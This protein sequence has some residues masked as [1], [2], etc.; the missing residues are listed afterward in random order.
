MMEAYWHWHWGPGPAA[1][2]SLSVISM[3]GHRKPGALPY[4][5]LPKQARYIC[6]PHQFK[7]DLNWPFCQ[8]RNGPTPYK[9]AAWDRRPVIYRNAFWIWAPLRSQG[10]GCGNA[11]LGLYA[12]TNTK[13]KYEVKP[14]SQ[15][16]C[17]RGICFVSKCEMQFFYLLKSP[18][19][20]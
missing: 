3:A 7:S 20:W 9:P 4:Y 18:R 13:T 14:T 16:G 8:L 17:D 6:S 1:D 19:R 11:A 12:Y 10:R 5:A 2:T 15:A